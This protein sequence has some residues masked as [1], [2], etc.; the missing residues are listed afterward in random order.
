MTQRKRT[1]VG[2]V[3]GKGNLKALCSDVTSLII[4]IHFVFLQ[5]LGRNVTGQSM[6]PAV[7]NVIS[8][9]PV[10]V[11]SIPIHINI[12]YSCNSFV[13]LLHHQRN[14][15]VVVVVGG[16]GG[17]RGGVRLEYAC[18]W[19]S[20]VLCIRWRCYARDDHNNNN[21]IYGVLFIV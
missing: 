14:L 2:I 12:D 19:C 20:S 8:D 10:Q 17:E 16:V 4:L 5:H 18:C 3:D 1:F 11:G 6:D 15:F 9:A 13:D 21:N 7:D